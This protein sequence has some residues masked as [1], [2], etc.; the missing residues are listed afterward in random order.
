M[1]IAEQ[2]RKEAILADHAF[3]RDRAFKSETDSS[4]V[5]PAKHVKPD[6]D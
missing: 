3:R 1:L 5:D 4:T 2:K 6:F